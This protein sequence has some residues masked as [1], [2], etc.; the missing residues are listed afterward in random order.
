[1]TMDDADADRY[2][3][4]LQCARPRRADPDALLRLQ[5]AHLQQVPFENLSI[6]WGEPMSLARDHLFDKLVVQRR[7]GFCYEC[8]G[9]LAELLQTLGFPTTLLSAR[10]ARGDGDYSPEF[11][12]LVLRVELATTWLVDVGFGHSF[13]A[14]LQLVPDLVQRDPGGAYRLCRDGDDW[15]LESQAAG[16]WAPTFRFGHEPRRLDAFQAMFEFHRDAPASHFR[17]A[18][19]ATIA[20]ADGRTTLSGRRL[21]RSTLAG[22]RTES[23]VA[24]P[25]Y[26]AVLAR[27]LGIVRRASQGTR[28]H[29]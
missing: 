6:H 14:P 16:D 21:I 28:P 4:R 10:V 27:E 18:P 23:E 26:P 13:R 9:L 7:G 11:D 2:L 12:H 3:A 25:D 15:R 24:E 19:L 22:H 20:T 8:N 17:K 5:Q 29:G 1:M